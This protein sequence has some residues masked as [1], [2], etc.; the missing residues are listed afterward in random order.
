MENTMK[1]NFNDK[2]V[3]KVAQAIYADLKASGAE[4]ENKEEMFKA[5]SKYVNI[6][7]EQFEDCL[8]QLD[9]NRELNEAELEMVT[10]GTFAEFMS[11]PGGKVAFVAAAVLACALFGSV[12]A[13]SVGALFAWGGVLDLGVTAG[14]EVV[15]AAASGVIA[16][17]LG[18]AVIGGI[19]AAVG[20]E[21]FK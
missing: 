19:G 6:T 20:D 10:G 4:V 1:V 9:E 16:G 8:S 12:M 15:A 5:V 3:Q 18:G 7:K 21:L 17:G 14:S 11:T 13:G 2:E